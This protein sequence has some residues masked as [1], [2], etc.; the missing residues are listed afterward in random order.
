MKSKFQ[1][2]HR[3]ETQS[4]LSEAADQRSS[5]LAIPHYDEYDVDDNV[6]VDDNDDDYEDYGKDED[7][8]FNPYS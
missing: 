7:K 4:F 6:F 5:L 8:L 2:C 1:N 3:D